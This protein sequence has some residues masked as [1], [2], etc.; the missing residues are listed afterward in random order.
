M[1]LPIELKLLFDMGLGSVSLLLWLRQGKVNKQ[2]VALDEKQNKATQDL[3][4]IV[5][6]HD[7]RIARLESQKKR[8]QSKKIVQKVKLAKKAR[9]PKK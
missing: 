3:A 7:V 8:R 1:D 6:D 4:V 5:K 9:G 2:Q